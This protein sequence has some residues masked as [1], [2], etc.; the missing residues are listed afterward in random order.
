MSRLTTYANRLPARRKGHLQVQRGGVLLITVLGLSLATLAALWYASRS[1]VTEQRTSLLQWR[2][3]Q[4]AQVADA[5]LEWALAAL[6]SGQLSSQCQPSSD[7]SATPLARWWLRRGLL[8]WDSLVINPGLY[9]S[10][11]YRLEQFAPITLAITA[12]QVFLV[13]AKSPLKSL[14]G[15]LDAAAASPGNEPRAV[16]TASR[17]ARATL[18]GCWRGGVLFCG[19]GGCGWGG[20]W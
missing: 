6:N 9:P 1:L 17:P 11:P 18:D 13:G 8:G 2:S 12:P 16:A 19:L 20:S 10:I 14:R 15:L 5:G 3:A 4:A 7:S